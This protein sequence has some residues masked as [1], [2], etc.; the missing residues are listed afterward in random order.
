MRRSHLKSCDTF[1][2]TTARR[3]DSR[4]A[5]W[6]V[7]EHP[8]PGGST[9]DGLLLD[10]GRQSSSHGVLPA[11]AKSRGARAKGS[12]HSSAAHLFFVVDRGRHVVVGDLGGEVETYGGG[13]ARDSMSSSPHAPPPLKRFARASFPSHV[14]PPQPVIIRDV[15]LPPYETRDRSASVSLFFRAAVQS[16]C[17]YFLSQGRGV[18]LSF[19][20]LA[21]R[22]FFFSSSNLN[23][24]LRALSERVYTNR[25]ASF[26]SCASCRGRV[27]CVAWSN[28]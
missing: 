15:L 12:L 2:P 6:C 26:S 25:H 16:T 28:P 18:T 8:T 9:K 22:L 1:E 13:R 11:F 4:G 5:A 24:P 3:S 17:I 23:S 7:G 14:A 21:V 27:A 10:D 20:T 19:G